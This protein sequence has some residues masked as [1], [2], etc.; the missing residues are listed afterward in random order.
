MLTFDAACLAFIILTLSLSVGAGVKG[1]LKRVNQGG[2][3]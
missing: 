3:G 2:A 1:E